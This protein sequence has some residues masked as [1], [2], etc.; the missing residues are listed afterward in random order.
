MEGVGSNLGDTGDSEG[1]I[2]R[3]AS[4][5]LKSSSKRFLPKVTLLEDSGGALSSAL[6]KDP[7]A[8]VPSDIR[9]TSPM[10]ESV[11]VS[12][13]AALAS[14]SSLSSSSEPSQTLS[15]AAAASA[16][17]A[18]AFAAAAAAAASAATAFASAAT[19]TAVAA[20]RN[21]ARRSAGDGTGSFK[22][23]K[24][25]KGICGESSEAMV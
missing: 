19:A 21:L 17:A 24:S 7:D 10:K 14:L 8:A 23:K 15:S 18:A 3:A 22:P 16:T 2:S 4:S 11:L 20:A 1:A 12:S 13:P 6:L 9:R 5:S 25:F